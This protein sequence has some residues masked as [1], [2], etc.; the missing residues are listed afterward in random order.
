MFTT[1]QKFPATYRQ[2]EL[3]GVRSQP[4]EI[5]SNRNELRWRHHETILQFRDAA[6]AHRPDSTFYTNAY[7]PSFMA[8][9]SAPS[10]TSP[11]NS[12]AAGMT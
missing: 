2:S 11:R 12:Y 4:A 9:P 6:Y 7:R 10:R 3:S 1:T 8:A 5:R